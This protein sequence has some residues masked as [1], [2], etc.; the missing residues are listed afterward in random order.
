M[1]EK[2]YWIVKSF[3]KLTL[4]ELYNMLHLR[5]D[6]F[7]VEQECPYLDPDNKDWKAI[8]VLGYNEEGL[9]AYCRLF[10]PGDYFSEAS[11][12]RVVVAKKWR[13]YGY[14]HQLMD[15][16]IELQRNQMK[17]REIVISAQMY[18]QYFYESH[19]FVREGDD[20]LEDNIPHLKMRL[21]LV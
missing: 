8:H 13:R 20:Y 14:G 12:G 5:A 7:V 9:A 17:E 10:G 11:I 4:R 15:K 2:L 6:V 16:A 18:L 19:G 1:S 3:D 21:R